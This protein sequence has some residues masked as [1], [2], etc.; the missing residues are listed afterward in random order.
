MKTE[1][2][3]YLALKSNI[4][5]AKPYNDFITYYQS[6]KQIGSLMHLFCDNFREGI[7]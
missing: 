2:E 1:E 6:F 7:Y 5:R 4:I 3:F